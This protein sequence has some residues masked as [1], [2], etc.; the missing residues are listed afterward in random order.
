MSSKKDEAPK[1]AAETLEGILT[2]VRRSLMFWKRSILVFILVA[3][4]AIPGVFLKARVYKSEVVVQYQET[5]KSTDLTGGEGSGENARRVGARLKEMLL[6]RASLEPIVTDLPRYAAIADRRGMQDAVEELRGHISFK[7]REGDTFE[8]GFEGTNPAEVRDVTRRLGERIVQ[9]A[10]S[11]RK[12]QGKATKDYLEAQSDQNKAKLRAAD[13]ALSSFLTLHPEFLPLTLPGGSA[14]SV[15]ALVVAPGGP[16]PPP[17]TKDPVLFQLESEAKGIE[18]QLRAASGAPPPAPAPAPASE[19][20]EVAAA[21]RDL[22][23]KRAQFTDQHPDVVAARRRLALA[24]EADKKTATPP[25]PPPTGGGRLSEADKDALEQRLAALRRSIQARR[26]GAPPPPPVSVARPAGSA[27]GDTAPGGSAVPGSAAVAFEVE[28]RRLQREVEYLKDAQ[29]Q[30]DDKL[31]KA[32]LNAGA[33]TSDRNIQ[34]SILDEAYL[35]V[36]PISKPR[37]TA[38]ATFLAAGII[39]AFLVALISA[40]LD[41]RI[42]QRADL[43]VLDILPVIGVIPSTAGSRRRQRG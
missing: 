42:Y 27:P 1:T 10:Q 12:E 8:I 4:A 28:F 20:P 37:S 31:F 39:L 35:P 15:A 3:L 11:R 22:A 23:E 29:R 38:L 19:G 32:D 14:K 33:N 5:I 7:A 40:R 36:H 25:P 26:S 17:G 13:G 9:E 34:V 2:F 18:R 41:D 24:I 16:A 43:E 21:R 6:A 30:L